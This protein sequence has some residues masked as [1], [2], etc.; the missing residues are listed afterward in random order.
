M[1]SDLPTERGMR[2]VAPSP[3]RMPMLISGWPKRRGHERLGKALD[4]LPGAVAGFGFEHRQ[5][6]FD[7]LRDVGAGTEGAR[8]ARQD[9]AANRRLGA[10]RLKR[11]RQRAKHLYI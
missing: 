10:C 2:W 6:A 7:H 5:A 11:G 4:R 1:A 8:V 9:H 3:G